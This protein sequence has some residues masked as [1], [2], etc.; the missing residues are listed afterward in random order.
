MVVTVV[1][2]E[3]V[4][5][6]V[7]VVGKYVVISTPIYHRAGFASACPAPTRAMHAHSASPCACVVWG[8]C[9]LQIAEA[10]QTEREM[11][12]RNRALPVY[13][14]ATLG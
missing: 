14:Q 13:T 2:G 3:V 8:H 7:E 6:V 12:V 10:V 1:V 11:S 4:G 5:V 9:R